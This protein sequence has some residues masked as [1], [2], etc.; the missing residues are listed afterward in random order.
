MAAI[1]KI[2]GTNEQYD[3]FYLWTKLHRPSMIG[4]FYPKNGYPPQD[5]PITN[6]SE[7]DDVWLLN[8]CNIDWVVARLKEQYDQK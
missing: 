2:Y 1:D 5:R 8:N 7:E 4:R 3:E 6:L